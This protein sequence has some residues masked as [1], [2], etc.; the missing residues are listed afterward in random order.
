MTIISP[1]EAAHAAVAR[2]GQNP[3]EIFAMVK[4]SPE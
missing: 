3:Q 4:P 1:M 2:N